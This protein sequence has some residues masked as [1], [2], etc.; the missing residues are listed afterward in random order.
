M[1]I[2]Y[3]GG[4]Y[5]TFVQWCLYY[6]SGM[7]GDELPFNHNGNSHKFNGRLIRAIDEWRA[8]LTDSK[9]DCV[10][11]L[12]PKTKKE[13]SLIENLNEIVSSV[14][15][16]ILVYCAYDS[17]L[18]NLNNKFEKVWAEGWLNHYEDQIKDNLSGWGKQDLRSMHLWE[19]REFL[20]FYIFPQ[21]LAETE[22]DNLLHF[23]DPKVFKL[24]I[25]RLFDDFELTVKQ[26][27]NFCNLPLKRNKF[28]EVFDAWL[29]LQKHYKKD[30]LVNDIIQAIA[31][32]AYFDW[33]ATSL[34]VV[35]EA[36]VQM[37]LRDLHKLDLR[38]YNLNVFPTNTKDL[39]ELLIDAKPV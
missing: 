2:I 21:H 11:R 19:L 14:D 5:G 17:L 10:V 3:S 32:G 37:Q 9:K 4:S 25:R 12:H 33:A 30:K 39:K 29:P 23:S 20:S 15:K 31:A 34:T 24:D 1:P 36:L 26:L 22:L 16:A 8:Y 7:T 38:C 28:K 6:F 13:E 18:L 27:L 35:D